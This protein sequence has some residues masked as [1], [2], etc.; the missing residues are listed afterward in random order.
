MRAVTAS[1]DLLRRYSPPPEL[2]RSAPRDVRL[3]GGGMTLMV[4]A[5]MLAINALPLGGMLYR[6]ARQQADA[7]AVMNTRGVSVP[8]TVDRLWRKTGD[9]KPAY[10]AVYFDAGGTRIYGERRMQLSAWEKL[11]V[12]S[13]VTAR[14]SPDNPQDWTVAGQ[15][16]RDQLPMPIPF[17][18][19]AIMLGTALLCGAAVRS[20]RSLLTD[21]R[22]A[23]A[24]VTSFSSHKGAH[25]N[26]H[27]AIRYEFPLLGGGS[28]KGK[29]SASKTAAAGDTICVIYDPDRPARSRPYPFSL[30]KPT[31]VG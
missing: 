1:S 30:V 31:P 8:A 3:T 27:H 20:Q 7:A 5:W 23:P 22:A 14:Y 17:V 19:S 21:G 28:E 16:R 13:I 11:Q 6:V 29:A 18:V 9:G 2:M 26:S 15:R 10:A 4:I 24:V 25:G 12:G